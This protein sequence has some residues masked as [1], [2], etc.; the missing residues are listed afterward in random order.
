[1]TFEVDFE[2]VQNCKE[3]M[4]ALGTENGMPYLG[5][6]KESEGDQVIWIFKDHI[7]GQS[8][9]DNGWVRTEILWAD[10]TKEELYDKTPD[11]HGDL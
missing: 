3:L 9:Q 4:K 11:D 6:G 2:N 10:G 7:T 5:R 8:M 1:M